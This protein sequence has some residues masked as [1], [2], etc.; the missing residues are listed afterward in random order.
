VGEVWDEGMFWGVARK[1]PVSIRYP[2]DDDTFRSLMV[3]EGS[4]I[5]ARFK[6]LGSWLNGAM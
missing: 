1:W 3:Y 4:E 2:M 6:G 5:V